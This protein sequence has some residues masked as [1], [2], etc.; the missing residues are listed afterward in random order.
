M[1]TLRV[2]HLNRKGARD[3]MAPPALLALGPAA[4]FA[5]G[6]EARHMAP[7]KQVLAWP[8]DRLRADPV[9]AL[10]QQ[11]SDRIPE[12]IPMR[13]HRMAQSPF[14]FFR[15]T[16]I[17]MAS[18]LGRDRPHSG[19][20]AQL[21]GDAHIG[22][23]GLFASPD[24]SLIFDINDFDETH[25]GPFE[26]DLMRLVAS[27]WLLARDNG[28]SDHA[29]GH[30]CREAAAAYRRAM[31]RYADMAEIDIWFERTEVDHL[32]ETISKMSGKSGLKRLEAGVAKALNRGSLSAVQKLTE[33]VHGERRFLNL[34]PGLIRI[35]LSET[36]RALIHAI[37]QEYLK[38]LRPAAASL[39]GRYRVVDAGHKIVGIGSVGLLAHLYLM[40]GRD[41][42]DL[43]VLQGKEVT[44][45]VLAPYTPDVAYETEGARVVLGQRLMQAAGDPFLGWVSGPLGRP[46]YVRQLRDMKYAPDFSTLP[47]AG[48]VSYAA[49]AAGALARG[50]AKTGDAIAIAAYLG[51]S[52][53]FD[54][55]LTAFAASYAQTVDADYS[56]FLTA[57]EAGQLQRSD[58]SDIELTFRTDSTPPRQHPADAWAG[59]LPRSL[60]ERAYS[61]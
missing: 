54:R 19:L 59:L 29:Q 17:L 43:L 37:Y 23:F 48:I 15:G 51:G 27:C 33:V 18:D 55:H 57:L 58:G 38:T 1:K 8:P 44:A 32:R 16:A 9:E 12:L 14:A 35:P 46:F 13:H 50:H 34:P 4:R 42:N 24:R 40:Q 25:R 52:D 26:W 21:C 61:V 3:P 60:L 11:A 10:I 2:H 30:I 20:M 47:P 39:L 31:H 53:H 41:E 28:F 22:N 6:K 45:S 49:H 5:R 56:R 7:R 36:A